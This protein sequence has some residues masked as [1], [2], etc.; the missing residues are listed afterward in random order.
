VN[1]YPNPFSTTLAVDIT[2]GKE[3]NTMLFEIIDLSGR[4]VYTEL[5]QNVPAG[6]SQV[7]L[8]SLGQITERGL[9]FLRVTTNAGETQTIKLV[10]Q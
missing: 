1:A 4:K 8:N 5:R 3:A 9:Y 7:R 2:L 6:K 10:K